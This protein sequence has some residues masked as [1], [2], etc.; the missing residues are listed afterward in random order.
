L[1]AIVSVA[2]RIDTITGILGI[3]MIPTGAQDPFALRRHT[4]AAIHILNGQGWRIDLGETLDFALAQLAGTIDEPAGVK[5]KI[6]EF[7]AGRLKGVFEPQGISH[8]IID[9][10]VSAGIDDLTAIGRRVSALASMKAERPEVY[11]PLGV[12]FKRVANISKGRAGGMVDPALFEAAIETTLHDALV[13]VSAEVGPLVAALEY[14]EAMEK[15]A[16][17]RPLVDQYFDDVLV[18]AEDEKVKEN[19]LNLLANLAALFAPIADFSKL[20]I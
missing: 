12:A 20:A 10:V 6:I 9:A 11:E 15:V 13:T 18:M 3:G 2:D 8:D 16:G 5:I 14:G 1:G 7:F 17:L 19:R 4:L